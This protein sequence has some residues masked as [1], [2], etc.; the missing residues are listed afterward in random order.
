VFAFLQANLK[1]TEV[2]LR[3]VEYASCNGM[4]RTLDPHS[5]FMS[6]EEWE[7]MKVNI[8]GHF[9]GLGIVIAIRDDT[10]T[11]MRPMPGTPAARAGLK[12]LDRIT[13]IN[14]ESTLNMPLED[15]VSRLRGEPSTKVTI[16]V[17][18]DGEGGWQ[19]SKP[20]ELVRETIRMDSVVSRPLEA[21]VGY[22][23][24]TNFQEDT[25]EDLKN[26][27]AALKAKQRLKGLVLDLRNNPGGSLEQ[28]IQVADRFVDHGVI[29]STVGPEG[30]EER[31]ATRRGTEPNYP[32][33]VLLNAQSASASEIVAGALK[34]LGRAVIVGQTSF[35]KGSV[36]SPYDDMPDGA[37]LK[38]TIAQYLVSGELS[39]QGVGVTPDVE[40][41]PMTADMLEMD[42]SRTEPR[43]NERDLS[44]SLSGAAKRTEPPFFRMRYNLPETELAQM[45]ERE[46][47]GDGDDEFRMDFPVRIARQLAGRLSPGSRQAELEEA[48]PLL[49][50]LQAEELSAMTSDLEKLGIDWRPPPK[51]QVLGPRASEFDVKVETDRKADAVEAGQSMTL[52]VTVKNHSKLPVY[53]LRAITKSDG[54]P[55]SYYNEKELLFGKIEP[56]KSHTATAPLG[57]CSVEG[58][59]PQ[60]TNPLPNNA[61]RTCKLPKAAA[62]RQDVV[63]LRFFAEGGEPPTDGEFRPTI[64]ALPRP[65]FAY[66]YDL[67]DNRPG[68]GDGQIARGEGV[69]MYLTVKNVGKGRSQQTKAYIRDLSGDGLLLQEGGFDLPDLKPGEQREVMMTFDVLSTLNRDDVKLEL[70]VVDREL[71]VF[72]TEKIVVPIVRTGLPITPATGRAAA[73]A[74][75]SLR[76]QP[77]DGARVFGALKKGAV[78]DRLGRYG[79]FTKLKLGPAR[80]G[81]AK[82]NLLKDTKDPQRVDYE[83]QLTHSPPLLEVSPS[84]LS[85]RDTRVRIEG[86]ATDPDGVQ[87]VYIFVG[88]HKVF[89]Q[90]NRKAADH[91]RLGFA[92]DIELQP[93][94][95]FIN[96]AARENEDTE[97][98]YTLVVRR[99]GPHGEALQTPKSELFGEDWDFGAEE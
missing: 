93:G 44:K 59:R 87:D 34:N 41:D 60:S 9:G 75:L 43:L 40:L 61:K 12:R 21:G 81:F 77:A 36:Q 52:K 25:G 86:Q 64:T 49:E 28:A 27:L 1:N 10:L 11:V 99:D 56:G 98:R 35:G 55:Y 57:W 17:H 95:N 31:R 38:L 63:K 84:K 22:V 74:S 51:E 33:V 69:T 67:V 53:Q 66:S 88:P 14:R 4:L 94:V 96:V 90:S 97:T 5:N 32:M 26:E 8:R 16:W 92:Q 73:V 79:E 15:A 76:A 7:D 3:D 50:K 78:A 68:N 85:T 58:S 62:T 23:K 72:S 54:G 48:R 19:S 65:I 39:I 13:K 70:N 18:R 89:Y 6:K 91:K 83:P 29:V 47:G 24:I 2:K 82:T 20:V 46:L 71:R 37:A 30:H 45:R 80:F 42:L